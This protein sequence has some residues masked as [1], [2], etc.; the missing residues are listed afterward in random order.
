MGSQLNTVIVIKSGGLQLKS[1]WSCSQSLLVM[2][3]RKL[4][5]IYMDGCLWVQFLAAMRNKCGALGK[6]TRWS[7]EELKHSSL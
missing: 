4:K 3:L 1:L 6:K 2:G 7:T 5:C